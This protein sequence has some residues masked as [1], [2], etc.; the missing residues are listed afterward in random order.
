MDSRWA[1]LIILLNRDP[2]LL[3]GG[4]VDKIEQP[5]QTDY[6]LSGYSMTLTFMVGGSRVVI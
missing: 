1:K 5:N 3:E 4:E 2:Q 6:F